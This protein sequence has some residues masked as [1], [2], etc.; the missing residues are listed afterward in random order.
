[1]KLKLTIILI[2]IFSIISYAAIG[3]GKS[4]AGSLTSKTTGVNELNRIVPATF[5][6]MQNY[7][8]PFNPTTTISYAL[9]E[10]AEVNLEVFDILGRRVA[11]LVNGNMPAGLYNLTFDAKGLNSGIYIYRLRAGSYIESRKLTLLK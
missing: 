5:G 2:F 4:T 7:P 3:V 1:M 9:P 6:L 8:N 10:A 11:T